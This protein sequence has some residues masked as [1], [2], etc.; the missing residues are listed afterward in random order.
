MSQLRCWINW[1]RLCSCITH[2]LATTPAVIT[3][4]QQRTECVKIS[5]WFNPDTT[6]NLLNSEEVLGW[7]PAYTD[8]DF[9]LIVH[10]ILQYHE[11]FPQE[12][13]SNM[14]LIVTTNL[15]TLEPCLI[16]SKGRAALSAAHMM[17][18]DKEAQQV[19]YRHPCCDW[20]NVMLGEWTV[21]KC[22]NKYTQRLSQLSS[23]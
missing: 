16:D 22:G 15:L 9:Y 8:S 19:I 4:V 14:I 17:G 5:E 12:N 11:T 13:S 2:L 3:N 21:A 7:K 23:Y 10:N 6:E 18:Y 1:Q 20:G